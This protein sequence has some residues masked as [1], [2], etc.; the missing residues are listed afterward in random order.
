[1][2]KITPLIKHK[3]HLIVAI[4]AFAAL[5]LVLIHFMY[6]VAFSL[7]SYACIILSC[8]FCALLSDGSK[9]WLF[10]QLGLIG[11]VGADFFLVF[12][13]VQI[14]VPGMIFF[15]GTQIAY[16]LRIYHEDE[17]RIRKRVHLILRACASIVGLIVTPLVLGARV[18]AVAV[19]SIFYYA[20][21]LCNV[22]FALLNFKSSR[23]FALALLFFILSDTLLGFQALSD[24]FLIPKG[25]FIY[26]AVLIGKRI[27]YPLYI[28][29]QVC[30]PISVR[31]RRKLNSESIS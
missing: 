1:V 6:N 27:F 23:L 20:N 13:P 12:L 31:G 19:I 8:L 25:S 22:L 10:T 15:C 28:L 30:I 9:S 5:E 11:T 21:L 24:Y 17:N 14:R 4:S 2:P 16:F 26:H 29:S 3:N 18:D 7:F